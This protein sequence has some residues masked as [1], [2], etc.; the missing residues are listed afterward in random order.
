MVSGPTCP[1]S[2]FTRTLFHINHESIHARP[3]LGGLIVLDPAFAAD[4]VFL[5][6]DP[7]NPPLKNY[8]TPLVPVD[9]INS[10]MTC[11]EAAEDDFAR[12]LLL[13]GAKWYDSDARLS[14]LSEMEYRAMGLSESQ[15]KADDE[16][17]V[18]RAWRLSDQPPPT[19]REKR[20]IRVGWPSQGDGVWIAEYDTSWGGVD[21]E[22]NAEPPIAPNGEIPEWAQLSLC[23]TMDERCRLLKEVFGAKFYPSLRE[24]E[25][26]GF[27]NAWEWDSIQQ[28][29][30]ERDKL[31]TFEQVGEQWGHRYYLKD[32]EL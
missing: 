3:S 8:L 6:L 28:G 19:M 32:W 13:L 30:G 14:V 12:R 4:F 15:G 26:H 20:L 2:L 16:V 29:N 10:S 21:D 18:D 31:L 11:G 25:G 27:F 17:R 7:L 22:H 23:R 9:A 1:Y 5:D 24:Y